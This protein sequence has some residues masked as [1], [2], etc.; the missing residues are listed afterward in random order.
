MYEEGVDGNGLGN[1]YH[2]VF[3]GP[4]SGAQPGPGHLAECAPR[5]GMG[6]PGGLGL[7]W[8]EWVG[9]VEMAWPG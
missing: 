8:A 4:T 3:T 2:F 5:D 1:T 7:T 9:L 6:W